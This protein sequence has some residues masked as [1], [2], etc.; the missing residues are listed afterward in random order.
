[1]LY[2]ESF[3]H[4]VRLAEIVSR[5]MVNQPQPKDVTNLKTILNFNS[6]IA[7][8]WVHRLMRQLLRGLY[9]KEPESFLAKNKGQLKD[10][11]VDHPILTNRR[12]EEMSA[13]YRRFP[14]DFYRE[15]PLDGRI[16]YHLENGQPLFS[17]ATRIKR[18]RRIAEKGSRRIVDFMFE[19]IRANADALAE[20]RARRLGI[21]KSQLI[22]PPAEMEEEFRHAER[23]LLKSIKKGTIQS[24]LPILSIPDVVGI[25]LIAEKDQ[26][27]RLLE[28][29]TSNAEC[30]LLEEERHSGN[31]NAVNLRIAHIIPKELLR[32]MSP[33]GEALKVLVKRG[34]DPLTVETEYQEFL[35]MAEDHV[36]LEIIVCDFQELLESEI[37]RSMHEERVVSQRSNGEYRANLAT[38]VRYLMTY[39]LG[40]CLAAGQ[41]GLM[42]VPIKLWVK[43]MPD[44]IDR[45]IRDLYNAPTDPS[46]DTPQEG[47]VTGPELEAA[48][49]A[50]DFGSELASAPVSPA[51]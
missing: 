43:Y 44:T 35:R 7:R 15:T 47:L 40:L 10:F 11:V 51:E 21:P 30:Q 8:I 36:L 5:W 24:E 32:S 22:T 29:L 41:E 1:M 13:R 3:V 42:D 33:S 17:G 28:A 27:Q 31:Y 46:F 38:N 19:R 18:H 39:I 12:V 48:A 26:Y 9:G 45:I 23:R 25:K 16:Y 37:G 20:E 14:E 4:R 50:L 34:F 49:P 6:Y 2:L